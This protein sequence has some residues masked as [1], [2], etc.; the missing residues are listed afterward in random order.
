MPTITAEECWDT[1]MVR[2]GR[3][4][5]HNVLGHEITIL[6]DAD[7]TGGAYTLFE[8]VVPPGNG[9]SPHVHLHED[10]LFYVLEGMLG[11]EVAGET[12]LATP[13]SVV[14][15][16]RGIPHG[17]RN[18]GVI[19]AR[20]LTLATP[21]GIEE[22]FAEMSD[23][24]PDAN[25]PDMLSVGQRHG[26]LAP[27]ALVPRTGRPWFLRDPGDA[28][29]CWNI[30]SE[31]LFCLAT[32]EETGG[33]LSLFIC[34]TPPEGRVP[35][36]THTREAQGFYVLDGAVDILLGGNSQTLSAG[37]FA[38]LPKNVPHAYQNAQNAPTRM[39]IISTPGGY[40]IF[41][42]DLRQLP[43]GA[44]DIDDV[45]TITG[46]HGIRLGKR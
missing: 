6:A 39:L 12:V 36:H 1:V 3:G 27:D 29:D 7:R 13:G 40:E 14:Y 24:A 21:G 31:R 30:Q 37:A 17:F 35:S 19:E 5:I 26:I 11:L 22:F 43:D 2:P 8:T 44:P 10:E 33:F 15:F 32:S 38:H 18:I 23:L 34:L 45:V 41:L 20:M 25:L 4:A 42:N 46:R 28:A 16:P 9:T